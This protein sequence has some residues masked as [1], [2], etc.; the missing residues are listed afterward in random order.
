MPG[1]SVG[2][3][4][5]ADLITLDETTAAPESYRGAVLSVGNFDGVH[6]GHAALVARLRA[7]ADAAGVPA[8]ALTFDPHP[9]RLL[10]PD[11]A[12][13]PL[14]WAGRKADLLAEAGATGVGVFRTGA[15]LLGLTASE[16]FDRLVVG[17][18][19]ATGMIEG[20]GFA[21]GRDR[22]G[23]AAELTA[24]CRSA[25]MGFEVVP[26]TLL[27][28]EAV[29]STRIRRCLIDGRADQ[30]AQLLGR[31]HRLRGMVVH[32][33]A[34]GRRIGFPTA[35]LDGVDTLVPAD[36]V[37]AAL[38][39]LDGRGP[40]HPTATHIGPNATYGER[41]RTVEAHFLD[42]EGD[43]YGRAIELDVLARTRPTRKFA[44]SEELLG[45]IRQDVREARALCDA[46]LR[47]A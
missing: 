25:G 36:G 19:G 24:W 21:F 46:H 17:R 28:G 34:R 10:R 41:A 39:Y 38:A 35:N 32:G 20:P 30:A 12:P 6:L 16:F 18:F 3:W 26:P 47:P 42:F 15:W 1:R 33:M 37:Y 44:G 11:T 9:A 45:Q 23:S 29:S 22:R 13:E 8:V 4:R 40:A 5:G 7:R 31:P 27:G 43:L 2:A 14:V